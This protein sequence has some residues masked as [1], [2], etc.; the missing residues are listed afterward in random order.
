MKLKKKTII[1]EFERNAE[2]VN[3]N[4]NVSDYFNNTKYCDFNMR[5]HVT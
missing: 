2:F 3:F 1:C 4:K 5:Q